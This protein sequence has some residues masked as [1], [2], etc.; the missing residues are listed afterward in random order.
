MIL[1]KCNDDHNFFLQ[2]YLVW[3]LSFLSPETRQW[4]SVTLAEKVIVLQTKRSIIRSQNYIFLHPPK[5]IFYH[6]S[7]QSRFFGLLTPKLLAHIFPLS[8]F[9][10][11][12][13]FYFFHEFCFPQ[14]FQAV[15]WIRSHFLRLQ[16]RIQPKILIGTWIQ[17]EN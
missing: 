5:A 15:F 10:S 6:E 8:N 16:I 4:R 14:I 17:E 11:I 1:T 9:R 12:L 7:S 2:N 3:C 13:N